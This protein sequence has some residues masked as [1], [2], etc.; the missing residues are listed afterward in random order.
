M[1]V[2]TRI[3]EIGLVSTNVTG[4]PSSFDCDIP[5][6]NGRLGTFIQ[7]AS[8]GQI[9][10]SSFLT[11]SVTS[12]KKTLQLTSTTQAEILVVDGPAGTPVDLQTWRVGGVVVADITATGALE[13][14]AISFQHDLTGP[15]AGGGNG[16]IAET[17]G[18]SLAVQSGDQSNGNIVLTAYDGGAV[19]GEI[20][21]QVGAGASTVCLWTATQT[22]LKNNYRLGWKTTVGG[23][24]GGATQPIMWL[25]A[26]DEVII[27]GGLA[28]TGG[29]LMTAGAGAT[30]L[31][32]GAGGTTLGFYGNAAVA[33]PSV[34]GSRGGNA[35]LASLLTALDTLGI[36]T[37]NTTA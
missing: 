7:S 35:A 13:A 5:L 12:D 32:W 29:K 18:G 3:T 30:C 4:E 27:G 11:W 31:T 26:A 21:L 24:G 36:I 17:F 25:S 37:N 20:Y 23:A 16:V 6:A 14:K 33:R 22:S 19:H 9:G 1:G 28:A 15:N 2:K 8:L 10:D 34:T